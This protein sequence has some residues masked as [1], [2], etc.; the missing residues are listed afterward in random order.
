[1]ASQKTNACAVGEAPGAIFIED[2]A[3]PVGII[4]SVTQLEELW[5]RL[6]TRGCREKAL[7][8]ALERRADELA[9]ALDGGEGAPALDLASLPR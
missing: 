2:G 6:N 4:T 7:A 1:M 3:G 8:A 5:A 9:A